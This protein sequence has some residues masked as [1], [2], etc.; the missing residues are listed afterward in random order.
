MLRF[1]TIAA[2]V[3][4]AAG[5]GLGGTAQAGPMPNAGVNAPASEA[6]PLEA[7]QFYWG[8][9]NY[10]WYSNGWNGPGWYWCGYPWR[11]GYGWGGGYGWRGWRHPGW[12]GGGGR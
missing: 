3:V 4:L 8:G 7:V 1:K 2:A 10:C 12:H 5:A 11:R 9:Y 6:L